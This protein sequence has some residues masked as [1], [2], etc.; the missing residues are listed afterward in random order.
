E[1]A[2]FDDGAKRVEEHGNIV[3]T[4]TFSKLYGLAGLRIGWAYAPPNIIETLQRIRT[5]FNTNGAALATATAAVQDKE[6][7]DFV[8]QHNAKW[9]MQI[10]EAL[11]KLGLTVI[12]SVTNFYLIRFDEFGTDG[13]AKA[14]EFLLQKNIIARPVSASGPENCLRLTIGL[15]EENRAVIQAFTEFVETYRKK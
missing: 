1:E 11:T 15:D 10:N 14:W 2:D 13:A 8:R 3:I 5:P 12:K 9:L 6:Y 7:A 4:R